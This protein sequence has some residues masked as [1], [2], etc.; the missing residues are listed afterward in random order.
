M[1]RLLRRGI[2]RCQDLRVCNVATVFGRRARR[3]RELLTQSVLP[4]ALLPA[5]PRGL[6]VLIGHY[7]YSTAVRRA[8]HAMQLCI[9]LKK[10]DEIC[11]VY[12]SGEENRGKHL[13]VDF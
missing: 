10:Y 13:K 5:V 8:S 1:V 4:A 7:S 2:R 6:S 11:A 3:W 9:V 12:P